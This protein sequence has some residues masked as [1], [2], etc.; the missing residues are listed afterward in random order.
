M[1]KTFLSRFAFLNK[2][3]RTKIGIAVVVIFLLVIGYYLFFHHTVTYQ[4]V[5]A[6]K[7]TITETV[8]LTGNTTPEQSV[9]LAFGSTGIISTTNSDLGKQVSAGQVLAELNMSDLLAGLHLAQANVSQQQAK[10]SSMQS[11]ARPEDIALYKQQYTDASSALLITMNNAYLQID[12]ALLHY[13]DTIFNNGT[14]A[15]PTIKV[16]TQNKS[17]EQSIENE[18]LIVG[19]KLDKWQGAMS[20]LNSAS[21]DQQLSD[22]RIIGR[23]AIDFSVAFFDHL[24]NIVGILDPNISGMPQAT[25]DTDRSNINTAAQMAITGSSAE[26]AAYAAWT[27]ASQ[28]LVSQQSGSKSQDIT[29]QQAA[30]AGAQAS[31]ESANAKIQNAEIIAPISGTITQFDAKIG[32]LAT[33]NVPLISIMSDTGYEVDAGV[34][35]TDVGKILVNDTVTMTLDAFPNE[36]FNG[37]VFYIAPSETNIQ[38]VISYQIKISFNKPDARFKSGLTANINIQTKQKDNVLVLPQ[39]AVLQND[40]GNFVEVLTNNVVKQIPVTLG[41]QD[42]KG[43]VEIVS[44]VTEGEQVIN[45]GLKVQ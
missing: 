7:G 40:V 5:T 6:K 19:E 2:F 36:T 32:Q 28:T 31:V 34:S 25:I 41:I 22:A 21:T 9:S 38:G 15:L 12:S 35:E 27:S 42:Q 18:R 1:E 45:I 26:Q 3:I 4:F 43:N 24:G 37:T 13:A 30:V 33:P 23:D 8:S 17:I 29:A 39:Y 11:G 16:M 10:L 20:N 14:G 44:G